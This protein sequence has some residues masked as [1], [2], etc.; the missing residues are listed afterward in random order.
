MFLIEVYFSRAYN[1]SLLY[2]KER[3]LS[4][5]I[6]HRLPSSIALSVFATASIFLRNDQSSNPSA[7]PTESAHDWEKAGA[8]W[9]NRASQLALEHADIPSF[10]TVQACQTIALYWLAQGQTQ[11]VNVHAN[12]AYRVC[13]LLGIH[14]NNSTADDPTTAELQRRCLWACW[15]TQCISQDNATFRGRCWNDVAGVPLPATEV[16]YI[17]NEPHPFECLSSDGEVKQT[18]RSSFDRSGTWSLMSELAK[19]VGFW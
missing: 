16:S 12:V 17:K 1:A 15:I 18:A 8:D 19:L 14:Q 5:W 4:D 6:G 7:A 9:A 3:F 10:E 13:R 11:R 2:H